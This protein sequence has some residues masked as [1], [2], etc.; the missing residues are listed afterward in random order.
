M[1]VMARNAKGGNSRSGG[2][3]VPAWVREWFWKLNQITL[4]L[5]AD[6][7]EQ[8]RH[9]CAVERLARE[10]HETAKQAQKTAKEAQETAR[11]AQETAK[12]AKR[13]AV[14][15]LQYAS[16]SLATLKAQVDLNTKVLKDLVLIVRDLK[17]S[18]GGNARL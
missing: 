12:E 16:R 13:V 1:R 3:E 10:A 17:K 7:R 14:G 6:L 18:G 4:R 15:V 8:R 11:Q 2:N 5:E 9:T